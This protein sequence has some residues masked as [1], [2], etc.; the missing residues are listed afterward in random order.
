MRSAPQR[1]LNPAH[2]GYDKSLENPYP[3]NP[4]KARQLLKEANFNFDQP[5]RL[6]TY[7][8]SIQNPRALIEAVAGY[9][10][11]GRDQDQCE[12][13]HRHR[14]CGTAWAGR[15]SRTT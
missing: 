7:T 13:L 12:C 10:E 4:E 5:L 15:E 6:V 3:Y 1:A 9:L 8:G 2:F 14:Y 11:Q